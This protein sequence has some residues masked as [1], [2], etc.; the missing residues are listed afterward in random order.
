MRSSLGPGALPLVLALR[1]PLRGLP[2]SIL[3]LDGNCFLSR[4][5]EMSFV[6]RGTVIL[7]EQRIAT[8][9]ATVP[10]WVMTV[11]GIGTRMVRE[12]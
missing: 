8:Y 5:C 7:I 1:G 2:I 4:S 12:P 10:V 9:C 6:R 11:E 3:Q